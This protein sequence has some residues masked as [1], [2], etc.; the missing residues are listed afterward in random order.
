MLSVDRGC[1][2]SKCWSAQMVINKSPLEW[3]LPGYGVERTLLR[4][5][6]SQPQPYTEGQPAQ[7]GYSHPSGSNNFSSRG[8]GRPQMS[9]GRGA[10]QSGRGRGNASNPFFGDFP[11]KAKCM[12]G[13]QPDG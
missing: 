11:S 4:D 9:R 6:M 12:D 2:V 10:F 7:G 8:R 5:T 3:D 1:R 13:Q